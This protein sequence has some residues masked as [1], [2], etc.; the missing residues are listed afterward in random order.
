M[1]GT[2]LMRYLCGDFFWVGLGVDIVEVGGSSAALLGHSGDEDS[3]QAR[4]TDNRVRRWDGG[5]GY[6][7]GKLRL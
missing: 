7:G 6:A 3:D 5:D 2:F 4:D 1:W